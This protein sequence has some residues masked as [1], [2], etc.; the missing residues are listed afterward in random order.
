MCLFQL[1]A[2]KLE[3]LAQETKKNRQPKD[4]KDAKG[5]QVVSDESQSDN[6]TE[7]DTPLSQ[8]TLDEMWVLCLIFYFPFKIIIIPTPLRLQLLLYIFSKHDNS[9]VVQV[10]SITC[11]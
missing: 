8:E 10:G 7:Q 4:K 2:K 1:R 6:K 5:K 9:L 3:D 11:C